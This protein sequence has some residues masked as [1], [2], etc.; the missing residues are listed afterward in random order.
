MTFT[1]EIKGVQYVGALN[2]GQVVLRLALT[3]HEIFIN[4]RGDLAEACG[5]LKG[6]RVKAEVDKRGRFYYGKS[7]TVLQD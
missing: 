4:C 5:L 2:H 7:F 1:G 6:K 3:K